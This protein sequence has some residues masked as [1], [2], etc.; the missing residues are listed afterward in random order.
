M[1]VFN[2]INVALIDGQGRETSHQL[3][4]QA[5]QD[6]V[7]EAQSVLTAWAALYQA[8]GGGG[9][10]SATVTFNLTLTPTAADA[11][12]KVGDTAWVKLLLT[13]GRK[14]SYGFPMP[15]KT[16]GVFNWIEGG[17]VVKTDT[18]LLAY[19]DQFKAAGNLAY[20]RYTA[21]PI[22][23]SGGVVGGYLDRD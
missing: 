13:D 19:F 20:G 6:T 3:V 10:A 8:A 23:D 1:T 12:S 5:D 4:L 7:A 2:T 17:N 9:I 14:P 16:D 15:K 11:D 21:T 22:A 18:D